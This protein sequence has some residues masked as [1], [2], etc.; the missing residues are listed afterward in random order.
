MIRLPAAMAACTCAGASCGAAASPSRR[1]RAA[2][3]DVVG[4][5]ATHRAPA[6]R[7]AIALPGLCVALRKLLDLGDVPAGVVVGVQRGGPIARRA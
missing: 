7:A 5:A 4:S 3:P 1:I 6:P 2:D